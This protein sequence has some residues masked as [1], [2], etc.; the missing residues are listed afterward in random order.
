[1]TDYRERYEMN[2]GG[3]GGR[4]ADYDDY[5]VGSPQDEKPPGYEEP[6][7]DSRSHVCSPSILCWLNLRCL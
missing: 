5:A 4:S 6:A 7:S 3:G 2:G 1:M